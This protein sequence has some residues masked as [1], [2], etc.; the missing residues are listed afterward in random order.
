MLTGVGDQPKRPGRRLLGRRR[1]RDARLAHRFLGLDE[2]TAD[3]RQLV[4]ELHRWALGLP[5]VNELDCVPS[6]PHVRRFAV[7]CP[8]LNC[9]AVWLL[10]GGYEAEVPDDLNVYAVLPR[11]LAHAVGG[12]GES[13]GPDLPDGRRFVAMGAP[14]RPDDLFGLEDVLL[15]AYMSVFEAAE[16]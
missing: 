14:R 10:T 2:P 3:A 7:D 8:P 5:F 6:V 9:S 1:R 11:S 12:A 13:L 4:D 15:V 16:T